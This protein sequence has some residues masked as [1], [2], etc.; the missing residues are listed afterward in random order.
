MYTWLLGISGNFLIDQ[1]RR[2]AIQKE[3]KNKK[4]IPSS[5]MNHNLKYILFYFLRARNS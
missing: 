4:N 2:V 3:T 1:G 5:I